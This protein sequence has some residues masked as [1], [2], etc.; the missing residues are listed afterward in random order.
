MS[1]PFLQAF[2]NADISIFSFRIFRESPFF[3][4]FFLIKK[5]LDAPQAAH[6]H[7]RKAGGRDNPFNKHRKQKQN[8]ARKSKKPPDIF[9]KIILRLNNKGMEQTYT[10]KTN[11]TYNYSRKVHTADPFKTILPRGKSLNPRWLFLQ[12]R[13]LTWLIFQHRSD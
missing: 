7:N 6:P 9:G 5:L 4:P 1:L 8:Y 3:N 10:N 12:K 2:S 13:H 11:Q